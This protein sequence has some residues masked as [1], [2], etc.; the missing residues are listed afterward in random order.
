[1]TTGPQMLKISDFWSVIS[2]QSIFAVNTGAMN[3]DKIKSDV[4]KCAYR[5]MVWKQLRVPRRKSI[6]CSM[7]WKKYFL[8]VRVKCYH[9]G[10]SRWPAMRKH[11]QNWLKISWAKLLVISEP[12]I[13]HK[14]NFHL[15]KSLY[16]WAIAVNHQNT[17]DAQL[18]S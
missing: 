2:T 10:R 5:S 9:R 12:K 6:R 3:R 14:G 17:K 15:S 13:K 7:K 1:M 8:F 16:L 18:M 11:T 4:M